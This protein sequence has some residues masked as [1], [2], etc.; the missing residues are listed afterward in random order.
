MTTVEGA[1]SIVGRNLRD[2]VRQQHAYVVG[3]ARG[4]VKLDAM[5]NPYGLP[6]DLTQVL[7]ERLSQVALNR[8]P[9]ASARLLRERIAQRS[10][11]SVKHDVLLGNGSDELISIMVAACARDD[12]CVL[13][14]G[15]GF[16]MYRMSAQI[17]R[18]RYVEVPLQAD[19]NI[20][21]AATLAAIETEKPNLIFIAYPNNPTGTLFRRADV[22]AVIAASQALVV[23]DEAYEAFS[24]D[25]FLAEVLES[26]RLLLLR[27]FSKVGLAGIRLGYLIGSRALLVEFDKVRPPYN[28]NVLTQCAAE[29]ALEHEEVLE[30]QAG[31]LVQQR[32]AL[33]LALAARTDVEV[34]ESNANF[35]LFRLNVEDADA[36]GKVFAGLRANGVL[37]KNVSQAHPLLR[38]CL[39]VTV[40]TP[41]ENEAFLTAFDRVWPGAISRAA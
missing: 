1:G 7:A 28:V 26:P 24:P 15:P 16:V 4:L 11:L 10:G 39:R 21:L 23:I 41:A 40:S 22:E 19:F 33:A 27:T 34:F 5:E 29:F 17:A 36:A 2:D 32:E 12:G 20:D 35:L 6:P 38:R 25:S 14:L 13:S 3:D 31:L 8:Y 30:Q 9:D 18:M 37:I